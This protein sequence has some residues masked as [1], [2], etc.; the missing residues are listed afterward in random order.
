MR[1]PQKLAGKIYNRFQNLFK[2]AY[3][4]DVGVL[5][6]GTSLAQALTVLVLP[7][8][9]RLYTPED[10]SVLAVYAALLGTISVAAC[11]R[12]E[13][14]IPIP[15]RHE[16]AA[17]LLALALCISAIVAVTVAFVVGLFPAQIVDLLERPELRPYLWLLPLGI[18]L[19]SS[20]AALQ[21]WFT[22]KKMFPIIAKT[23]VTQAIGGAATQVGL[24]WAGFAPFGLLLGQMISSGVGVYRLGHDALTRDRIVF[25]SISWASMR[26]V[27]REYDRFP[28]YS[29][30]EALANT[31]GIQLPML[32]IAA[33]A[34]G[35]E[36]GFLMLATRAM[37]MPMGL[38][39][40]SVSQVY[41][42]QAPHELRRGN[43]G[44]F[45]AKVLGGLVKTGVGPLLFAGIVA[46]P[47]FALIF[48]E[49]WRRAGELVTWM[50]PWFVFQFLSS[51]ISMVMHIRNKQRAMLILVVFGLV[52]RV[53]A[54]LLAVQF[55]RSWMS[56]FYILASA[57]YYIAICVPLYY[58]ANC[59][60]TQ[61]ML[62]IWNNIHWVALWVFA[63]IIIR[64]LAVIL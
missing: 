53:S 9:T 64:Y 16:D 46:I 29:T 40:V 8:L 20:Y 56:E 60:L 62:V 34:L 2:N 45:T 6:G 41:L 38:I 44:N 61:I 18:W 24:G 19:A 22:R 43:L 37:Q 50:T 27:Y 39:G 35:P 33:L 10:F 47:A 28:K 51:P 31:A 30:W 25:N 26:R 14:A 52:I 58:Q 5:A 63:G 17:N 1:Q 23:R 13:I 7:V 15:E 11:L 48:G 42:S 59:K 3:V 54:I 32:I 12:L 4:R 36:A 57:V 55:N 21:Y 49:D